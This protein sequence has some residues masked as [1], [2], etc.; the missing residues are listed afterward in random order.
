MNS[1]T[2][3][4]AFCISLLCLIGGAQ[5]QKA[6][7][8]P[9]VQGKY[10]KFEKIADGV[11]Y[12]SPE[13]NGTPCPFG[14]NPFFGA[15]LVVIVNKD[16]VVLVDSP[17]TPR[18]AHALL[19]DIKRLTSK[20][21]RTVINT[22]WHYDHTDAN[23]VFGPDVQII[24]HDYVRQAIKKFDILNNEPFRSSHRNSGPAL[25][26]RFQKQIVAEKNP[27]HKAALQRNLA[28]AQAALKEFVGDIKAIKPT[29]PNV[30]YSDR[31]VLHRG[32][33]EIQLLFLG[34]G[35]TGGD[36]VVFLPRERIVATGDLME[37]RLAY[38]GSAFFDEWI[39]TLGALKQLN[40]A[41][42]LPGHGVPFTDKGLVTAYQAYLADVM[43]QAAK[44]RAQGVSADDAA[45][46]VDLTAH[47]KDFP[48]I[49]GVGAE[50]R[51]IRRVYAW[52]D[53]T[54]RK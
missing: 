2:A 45:R 30:T 37:S 36:T 5:A 46:R 22:H 51:G 11:Y 33:R 9:V 34:R 15:N 41:V 31:L 35:H 26:A 27:A 23:S 6:P 8:Y 54:G 53:E 13:L 24:A 1:R 42:T 39:K 21:V 14:S 32:T 40:W 19:E 48:D 3:A 16:D 28:D 47:A 29:P 18:A 4:F 49:E 50:V 52:M 43:A 44:L 20:P 7:I 25:V 17:T 12:A 38:M 10:Y